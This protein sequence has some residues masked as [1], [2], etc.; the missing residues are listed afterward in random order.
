MSSGAAAAD[1][2][3]KAIIGI[4][5]GVMEQ[6]QVDAAN[7]VNEANAYAQNLVRA[8]NNNLRGSRA[9][10]SRF[11]Q[12]INNQRVMENAGSAMEAAVVN[13]RRARDNAINDDIEAQLAFSE[14]AGAQ[15]AASALSG[16][17][18]GAA[19]IV[20]GTTAL[21]KSRLKQ[22]SDEALRLADYDAAKRSQQI[23]QAGWDSLDS[24][25][26]SAD[27]DYSVDVATK[28][29]RAGNLLF[30]ILGGQDTKTVANLSSSS[31]SWFRTVPSNNE[32]TIP[33]QRGGGY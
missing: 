33:M 19:D 21:R 10:L 20:A 7:I 22:R 1:F 12:S 15:A 18:G 6:G 2:G 11:N 4:G 28:Q 31:G 32:T 14:Q 13:Y 29:T 26:I 16:L 9:S 23:M 30:D 25:E 5:R 27:L 3:M 8:A 24:S 17:V